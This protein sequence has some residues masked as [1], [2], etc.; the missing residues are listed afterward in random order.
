MRLR[1]TT[2]ERGSRTR[3]AAVNGNARRRAAGR[4]GVLPFRCAA[5]DLTRRRAV[6]YCR[7]TAAL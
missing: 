2:V 1:A 6:D 4:P 5:V 7:V 3:G